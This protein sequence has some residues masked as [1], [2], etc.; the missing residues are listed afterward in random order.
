MYTDF[1]LNGQAHG[2]LANN[3][4]GM[5]GVGEVRFDPGLRRPYI[6]E[7]GERCCD[8]MTGNTVELK[9]PEGNIVINKQDGLP[10][11]V[12]EKEVIPVR[13]LQEWGINSPVFNATTMSKDQWIRLDAR[14]I[15]ESRKRL[16]A[17]GDLRAANT[18]GGFDG[19]TTTILEHETITDDGE[20]IV[21]MDGIAT[22]RGDV[23][24]YQLEGL[25]L[26]ITH[27]SF[28]YSQRFINTARTRRQPLSFIRAEAAARRVAETIE[29]TLIGTIDGLQYGTSANY[30]RTPKVYGYRN[31]PDVITK[32]DLTASS[33]FVGKTFVDEVIAMRELAYDDNFYGPFMLYVSTGYDA[34]LDEDYKATEASSTQTVRQR[35]M[36][37]DQISGV[38]RL[39]YLTGDEVLL[40]QMTPNVVEAVNG[41]EITTVQWE[42]MGGSKLY[43]RVMGIQVPS[44]K[45]DARGTTGI[46]YGT[47]S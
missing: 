32:N 37:I 46:V 3:L 40:V 7:D 38:K 21:D 14:V 11:M 36:E 5:R 30:G 10:V 16:R 13:K 33:S 20:A 34:H 4:D 24:H 18:F 31:F 2:E 27:S 44:I 8:V 25:P 1:I 47:T 42:E 15:Q 45:A 19:M 26:P 41:M 43:F 22:G 9:D 29:Q 39:D 23:S 12:P 17:W 28:W 35:L 6:D